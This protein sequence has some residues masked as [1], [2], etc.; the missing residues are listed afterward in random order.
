MNKTE[1]VWEEDSEWKWRK[2]KRYEEERGIEEGVENTREE[3]ENFLKNGKEEYT[4]IL[5]KKVTY[6]IK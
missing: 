5:V 2:I 6:D 4:E 1:K 3:R